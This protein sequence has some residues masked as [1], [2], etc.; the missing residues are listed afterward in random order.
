MRTQ[1]AAN[2]KKKKEMQHKSPSN[3]FR[4]TPPGCEQLAS[5]LLKSFRIFPTSM[6]ATGG[7]P[8]VEGMPTCRA[9]GW[10]TDDKKEKG[11]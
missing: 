5:S 2:Q 6:Y 8:V 9:A 4:I 7:V 10:G 1:N 11:R 3:S